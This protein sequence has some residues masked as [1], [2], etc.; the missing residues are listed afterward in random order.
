MNHVASRDASGAVLAS[1]LIA[2]M[3]LALLNR[4]GAYHVCREITESC[5]D[6]FAGT[7][8]WRLRGTLPENRNMRRILARLML[9]EIAH[10]GIRA[11]LPARR[12]E[13]ERVLYMDP[14]YV[15]LGRPQREDVVLCHDMGPI[16]HPQLFGPDTEASYRLAF[17]LIRKERPGMV[18]VS[19]ASRDAFVDLY[20]SDFRFLEVIPLFVRSMTSTVEGTPPPGVSGRFLLTVGALERRKNYLRTFE[21]FAASG[22]AEQGWSYVFCGPRG[23]AADEISQRARATPGVVQLGYVRDAELQWLYRSASGFVLVSLLEGFGIPALEA[24]QY[25]LLSLVGDGGAQREAVGEGGLHVDPLSVEA[26]TEGLRRL[27]TMTDE[28]RTSRVAMV[29]AH[30]ASLSRD[31]FVDAWRRLL[32]RESGLGVSQQSPAS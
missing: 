2:D 26:I 28:E 11:M 1:P 29:R 24:A 27:A 6:F 18:F 23:N 19:A 7:L 31:A 3:S 32:L 16:T 17:D 21:A 9:G 15:I 25:G 8:H 22:L 30:A 14:L 4:T 10:P 13:G 20:G 12:R 5:A